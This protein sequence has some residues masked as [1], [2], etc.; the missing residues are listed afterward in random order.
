MPTTELAGKV[1]TVLGTLKPEEL[2]ITLMHEHCLIDMTSWF[3]DPAEASLRYM[4]RK[5]IT[6]DNLSWVR[7]H[8][9]DS[10][11]NL[12]LIDEELAIRELHYYKRSGGRSLVDVT[13][14]G[15]ARDPLALARMARATGLQIIMGSGYYTASSHPHD[16]DRKTDD[17]IAEEIKLDITLGADSTSVRAGIIGEIGCSWPLTD[18]ERKVLR[19]S[20]LAQQL[21]GAAIIVHPG[22]HES[23][24]TQ[25]LDV[26][27]DAGADI[28]RTIIGHADRGIFKHSRRL[29]I[30][31]DCAKTGCYIEYD[32]FGH[33]SYFP[34]RIAPKRGIDRLN[35]RQRIDDI[36]ILIDKGFLSQILIS[37]DCCM[38]TNLCRY[39]GGGYAHILN[40]ALPVMRENGIPDE[41][42]FTIM[43][44]NPKHI[45]TFK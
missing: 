20:A 9:M 5:P 33:E 26:L 29:K 1:Q 4:A 3:A 45:L 37:Q 16:M 28:S 41:A 22:H 35:D 25:A 17:E 8:P 6:W 2:G 15:I 7:Y 24:Y 27:A 34:L 23:A 40:N 42:I 31:E 38:K 19:A 18:N 11:D 21:T 44:E 43:V 32:T 36:A 10:Y 39:G 14:K 12:R 30:L 13:S